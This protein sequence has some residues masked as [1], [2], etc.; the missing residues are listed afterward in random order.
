MATEEQ[1]DPEL[2]KKLGVRVVP[3]DYSNID[4][5][6][7]TF[8]DNQIDTVINTFGVLRD[9]TPLFN[10]LKAADKSKSTKRYI[11]SLWSGMLYGPE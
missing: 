11:P 3:V 9:S 7:K 4:A 2:E 8:E 5:L 10:V 1:A 6:V